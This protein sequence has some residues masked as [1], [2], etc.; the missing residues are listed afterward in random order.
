LLDRDADVP[1]VDTLY[2]ADQIKGLLKYTFADGMS[3]TARGNIPGVLTGLTGTPN[4]AGVTLYATLGTGAGNALV[5][6]TDTAASDANIS[7]GPFTTWSTPQPTRC[8][9]AWPLR[10]T[11]AR[12][13][14]RSGYAPT[15]QSALGSQGLLWPRPY[16]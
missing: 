13:D 10:P 8:F 15:L 11:A 9:A 5:T 6:F 14:N 7:A 1:G 16:G 3:W 4:G 2:I 12:R